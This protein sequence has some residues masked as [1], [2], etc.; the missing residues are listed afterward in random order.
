MALSKRFNFTRVFNSNE[1]DHVNFV[2][3]G[4]K[5]YSLFDINLISIHE[6]DLHKIVIFAFCFVSEYSF[7]FALISDLPQ[8]KIML[9]FITFNCLQMGIFNFSKNLQN[10]VG[11]LCLKTCNDIYYDIV[12]ITRN[13]WEENDR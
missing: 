8:F 6:H 5:R 13:T 7:L 10:G 9:T 4:I 12:D 1:P 3:F 2:P 11:K